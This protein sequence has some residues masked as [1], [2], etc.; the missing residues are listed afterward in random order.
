V[1][2]TCTTPSACSPLTFATCTWFIIT[3]RI[4][5]SALR[6][7]WLHPPRRVWSSRQTGS[8][9]LYR[10]DHTESSRTAAPVGIRVK[11]TISPNRSPSRSASGHGR[12]FGATHAC[13]S[14]ASVSRPSTGA[15]PG[16]L[17]AKSRHLDHGRRTDQFDPNQTFERRCAG[18]GTRTGR[19]TADAV[20]ATQLPAL[21]AAGLAA[22]AGR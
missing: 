6:S 20:C 2:R 14:T 16:L 7:C 5:V 22:A 4:L 18:C 21:C 10:D 1:P 3:A 12:R 11:L 13:F 17:S 8:Q 15:S 19:R 9:S